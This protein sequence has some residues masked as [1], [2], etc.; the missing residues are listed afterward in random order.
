VTHLAYDGRDPLPLEAFM[1][2]GTRIT[3]ALTIVLGAIV[4]GCTSSGGTLPNPPQAPGPKLSATYTSGISASAALDGGV[5]GPDGRIWFAEFNAS[6]LAAVTTSGTV[7]EYPMGGGTQPCSI[8]VGPDGNLWTGGY[9]PSIEKVNTS[10]TV[11][12]TYSVAGAHICSIISGPGGL[13]WFADYGNNK[14]GTISTS[15]TVNE[16]SLPA[17]AQPIGIAVGSDG[18]LWVTDVTTD[19]ILKVSPSGSVLAQYSSGISAGESPQ[20]I[21]AAPDKNLYFTEAAFNASKHDKVGRITTGGTITEV[22]T[23][24]PQSYPDGITVGKDG[25][26]YFTEYDATRL[27]RVVLPSGTVSDSSPGIGTGAQAIVAG[28][29]GRLWIGTSQTLYALQY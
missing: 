2:L 24:A 12:S 29:D 3:A 10:G 5:N 15:G 20:Y 6:N 19:T 4:A 8:A 1:R 23:L 28:S 7:T 14:V 26:V 11:L 18:N 25:N 16:Y 22:G 17:G 13:L 27:G 21:V 9:G